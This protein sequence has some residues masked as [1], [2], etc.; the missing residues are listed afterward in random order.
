[1][2]FQI[3]ILKVRISQEIFIRQRKRSLFSRYLECGILGIGATGSVKKVDDLVNSDKI[4]ALK[5]VNKKETEEIRTPDNKILNE[6]DILKELDHPNILNLYEYTEDK[7]N[8]YLILDYIKGG[9]LINFVNESTE[10]QISENIAAHIMKQV[11]SVIL[12]C[13]KN[14]IIHRYFSYISL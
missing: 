2:Y 9:E 1:M 5:C 13:H 8:F 6:I 3:F 14:H 7:E 4:R 10:K 12:Y 11:L